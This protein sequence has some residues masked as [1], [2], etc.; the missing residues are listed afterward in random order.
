MQTYNLTKF[1]RTSQHLLQPNTGCYYRQK[2]IPGT[3]LAD[4]PA[5][6]SG[7]LSLGQNLV[8]AY[9]SFDGLGYEDAIV[10]S[11]KLVTQDLLTSIHI[12]EYEADVVDTKLG[13]EELTRDIPNVGEIYLANLDEGGIVTVGPE[14]RPN[15]IL[16][17][18]IAPKGET[19]LS[20]EERLLRAIFGKKPATSATPPPHASRRAGNCGR[21]SDS[22]SRHRRRTS[23]RH[24]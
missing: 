18:K 13:P 2:V 5:T 9:T 3:L 8:I 17:G 20:A 15:D 23:S 10:I 24:P 4:G 12:E 21:H 16:V 1:K 19:E 6:D 11:D 22:R 14:V 7:E